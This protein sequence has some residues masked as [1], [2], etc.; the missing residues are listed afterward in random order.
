[1]IFPRP[2]Y[3]AAIQGEYE[4]C[5]GFE[6]ELEDLPCSSVFY[7]FSANRYGVPKKEDTQAGGCLV[8]YESGYD[9]VNQKWLKTTHVPQ[10][11]LLGGKVS[12]TGGHSCFSSGQTDYATSGCEHFGISLGAGGN[13]SATKYRWLIE[14]SF[15]PGSL[16]QS[17]TRVGIPAVNWNIYAGAGANGGNVVAAAIAAEPP[18]SVCGGCWKWGEPKW[19]K[20]FVTEIEYDVDLDHLLTD[21]NEVPQSSSET[22]IEWV[23]LQSPPTCDGDTCQAIDT[24]GR[25]E[26]ALEAEAGD[27]CKSIIRRYE[28]YEYTGAVNTED[29]EANPNNGG[30]GCESDPESCAIVGNYL[31]AQ[32][33]AAVLGLGD[34]LVI[35]TQSPV[36][37]GVEGVEYLLILSALGGTGPYNWCLTNGTLFSGLE[38]TVDGS[39]TGTSTEPGTRTFEVTVMDD[40][41]DSFTKDLALTI[42]PHVSG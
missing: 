34:D 9:G 12:P 11:L 28:F 5:H 10:S 13:P 24:E 42:A 3:I 21:G 30:A 14:N 29:N 18:K 15:S 7:T 16:I 36:L 6:I 35:A 26:L 1:M 8:T 2:I 19:V 37:S 31:G 23:L 20:V 4:D 39:V 25:D 32:M 22:E 27:A 33:A 40:N 38:L 41:G 17:A